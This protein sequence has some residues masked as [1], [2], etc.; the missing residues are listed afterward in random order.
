MRIRT[1]ALATLAAATMGITAMST[2]A[3]AEQAPAPEK[4]RSCVMDVSSGTTSCYRTFTEAI[5]EATG[6]KIADAPADASAGVKDP[7]LAARLNATSKK[8]NT[9]TVNRVAADIV[10]GIEYEDSD[11]EDSSLIYSAP[12]GCTGPINDFDWGVA[13]L[14]SG[15]N[16]QIGS[17]RGYGGCWV[18]HFEHI[19]YTGVFTAFDSGQADMG[20]MDDEASS[21]QWS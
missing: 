15:W 6:G 16:D 8:T 18:R 14:P 5:A 13:S 19:N 20:W 7:R 9:G 10:I 21:I 11:F 17:Y 1:L 2:A 3:A 12:W 4:D